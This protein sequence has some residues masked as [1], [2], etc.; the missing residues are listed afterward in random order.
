MIF[1]F[2]R[3]SKRVVVSLSLPSDLKLLIDGISFAEECTV[4]EVIRS[5]LTASIEEYKKSKTIPDL[6]ERRMAVKPGKAKSFSVASITDG[7]H[8]FYCQNQYCPNKGKKFRKD[9]MIGVGLL[10]VCSEDCET[11]IKENGV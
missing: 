6:K 11:D 9:E 2:V 3:E 1:N 5:L 4:N 10:L 8:M 7:Q